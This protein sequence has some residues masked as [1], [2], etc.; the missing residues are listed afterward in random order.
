MVKNHPLYANSSLSKIEKPE[1]IHLFTAAGEG[2]ALAMVLLEKS[3]KAWATGVVNLIHAYDP[4]LIIIGGGIMRQQQIILPYIRKMVDQYSWLPP[5][6][7]RIVAAQQLDYA[8]L[9]G[10]E[11]LTHSL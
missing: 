7:A 11:Y 3:L 9:L 4:E 5:G 8:G 1:Y 6:T 10:M 2:D